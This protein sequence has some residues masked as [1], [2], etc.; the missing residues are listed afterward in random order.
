DTPINAVLKPGESW[1]VNE[2]E[3]VLENPTFNPGCSG[4]LGFEIVIRNKSS[5]NKKIESRRIYISDDKSNNYENIYFKTGV[6]SP[7]CYSNTLAS[8]QIGQIESDSYK[9]YAF[10]STMEMKKGINEIIVMIPEVYERISP[11]WS[12]DIISGQ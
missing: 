1:Y 11:R 5:N 10:R 2:L 7:A 4:S 9:D 3:I 6:A 8:F 12:I